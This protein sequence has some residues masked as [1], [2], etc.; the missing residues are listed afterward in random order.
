MRSQPH[1][2]TFLEKIFVITSDFEGGDVSTPKTIRACWAVLCLLS[3]VEGELAL[4]VCIHDHFGEVIKLNEAVLVAVSLHKHLHL[5][6]ISGKL[7][8][9]HAPYFSISGSMAWPYKSPPSGIH[10]SMGKQGRG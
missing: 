7:N 10:A 6:D 5:T 3:E 4:Y 2:L 8:T 1:L 9:S